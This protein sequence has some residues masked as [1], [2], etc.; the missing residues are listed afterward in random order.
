MYVVMHLNCLAH[1]NSHPNALSFSS[2][3]CLKQHPKAKTFL[4]VIQIWL[5]K[6]VPIKGTK[7]GIFGH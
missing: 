3:T 6:L 2:M 7:A 1:L 4:F 5:K